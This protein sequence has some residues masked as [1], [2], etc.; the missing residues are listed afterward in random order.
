MADG[1]GANFTAVEKENSMKKFEPVLIRPNW[2]P[3]TYE[4]DPKKEAE[5]FF[6]LI[7]LGVVS[8]ERAEEDLLMS[9]K[10]KIWLMQTFPREDWIIE[11][12]FFLRQDALKA[13]RYL[14]VHPEAATKRPFPHQK[15]RRPSSAMA[16]SS[17]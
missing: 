1:A 10:Q 16:E 7:L 11:R 13:L 14:M 5:F 17:P 2:D 6:H 3:L 9:E 8:P 15:R 4:W 12:I